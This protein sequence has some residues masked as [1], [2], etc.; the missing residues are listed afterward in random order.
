MW[1]A[2]GRLFAWW[3][4]H[5]TPPLDIYAY[6]PAYVRVMSVDGSERD[7]SNAESQTFAPDGSLCGWSI[8]LP[9]D[10]SRQWSCVGQEG[11]L[12]NPHYT[13][14]ELERVS[15]E[16]SPDRR[17]ITYVVFS[18]EGSEVFLEDTRSGEATQ[19]TSTL[20]KR[21]SSPAFSPDG[22]AIAWGS[23]TD[24]EAEIVIYD[25]ASGGT[26]TL[27]LDVD[28]EFSD[29][30]RFA[31]M[32]WG[33]LPVNCA[34]RRA[35]QVGTEGPDVLVGTGKA[36]V[37][38]GLGGDDRIRGR[39]GNDRICGGLGNDKLKGGPGKDRVRP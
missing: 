32:S 16:W 25:R 30:P 15:P 5:D 11:R 3:H 19:L 7:A 13:P 20:D 24:S 8:P 17:L 39:K 26:R 12:R 9:T 4:E 37:L 1:S 10:G 22:S 14:K 28:I 35:N 6:K 33:P 21:E 38:A 2:S 36:D 27:P 23:A 31:G 29:G 34:G 18:G